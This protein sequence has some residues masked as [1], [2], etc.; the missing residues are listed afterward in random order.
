MAAVSDRMV[1]LISGDIAFLYDV[2]GLWHNAS[3]KNLRI[4]VVNNGGGNIFKI[5]DGPSSTNALETVFEARHDLT[6]RSI[7]AHFGLNYYAVAN[8]D[9]L[10]ATLPQFYAAGQGAAVLEVDTR[11]VANERVLH[12]MFKQLKDRITQQ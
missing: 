4:I 8:A 6:A 1:T 10:T 5:I 11:D 7:A 12:Q 9:E 2:N 3:R